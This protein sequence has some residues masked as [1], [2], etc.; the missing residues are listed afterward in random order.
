[1][2][3]DD[4]TGFH[5]LKLLQEFVRNKGLLQDPGKRHLRRPRTCIFTTSRLEGLEYAD[6]VYL[7]SRRTGVTELQKDQWSD[8]L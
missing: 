2:Q 3:L 8:D 6:K 1:M 5:V 7:C 4:K